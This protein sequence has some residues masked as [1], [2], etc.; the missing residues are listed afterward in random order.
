MNNNCNSFVT[1]DNN[2][3]SQT[4]NNSK[5][6]LYNGILG[7]DKHQCTT[8]ASYSTRSILLR[9]DFNIYSSKILTYTTL[10]NILSKPLIPGPSINIITVM[11]KFRR[12][13]AINKYGLIL[14]DDVDED[15]Y[16]FKSFGKSMMRTLHFVPRPRSDLTL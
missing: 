7:P 10:C 9:M 8:S 6:V 13:K 11:P 12:K 5:L 16:V 1:I 3:S 14:Y 2:Y 4:I 15:L